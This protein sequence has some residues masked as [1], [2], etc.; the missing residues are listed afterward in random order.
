MG[1]SPAA[2][3]A[4]NERLIYALITGFGTEGP[5]ADA[6]TFDIGAWWSRGAIASLLTP[7]GGDPPFQRGGMGDHTI[8]MTAAAMICAALYNRHVTGKGQPQLGEHTDEV[9]APP[10]PTP[11][12]ANPKGA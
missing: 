12:T 4:R 1:M 9:L 6:A 11:R 10:R 8:G 7:P 3:L 2:L 5:D